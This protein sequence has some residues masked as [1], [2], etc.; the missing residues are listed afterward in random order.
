[1]N[2]I[3]QVVFRESTLGAHIKSAPWTDMSGFSWKAARFFE[4]KS[5]GAGSGV[6]S[7]RPQLSDAQA[8]SYTRQTYLAGSDGWNPVH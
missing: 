5:T 6:N 3:A 1:V 7:N 4:Y 8:P 2:A